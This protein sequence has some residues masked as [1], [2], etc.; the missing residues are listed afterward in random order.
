M[1]NRLD[2]NHVRGAADHI[3]GVGAD[4]EIFQPLVYAQRRRPLS[5]SLREVKTSEGPA[6]RPRRLDHVFP[7][8]V[9]V[10]TCL[11]NQAKRLFDS[12][13]PLHLSFL[14]LDLIS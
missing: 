10:L 1:E 12:F 8:K 14:D 3:D 13:A 4:G 7:C 9:K 5:P 11:L 6:Y 2:F